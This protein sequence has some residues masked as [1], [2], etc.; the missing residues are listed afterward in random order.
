MS[1]GT[2]PTASDASQRELFGIV[3]QVLK[4][5]FGSN[6]RMVALRRQPSQFRTSFAIDEFEIGLDEGTVL[7]M[8]RKDLSRA[9]LH[10]SALR[11]KPA[12][13]HDPLREIEVYRHVL[14]DV[15]LGTAHCYAAVVDPPRERY[16][17]FLEHVP[18]VELYQVGDLS[19]WRDVARWL[20]AMHCRFVGRTGALARVAPL[21]H[22]DAAFYGRWLDRAGAFVRQAT[23][24]LDAASG[25][26]WERLVR[27]YDRVIARLAAR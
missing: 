2:S 21:L 11:A 3:E 16:W 23:R 24:R 25:A 20:A 18:G 17:L 5:A 7:R 4:G 12:F 9:G 26:R 14:A 8:L 15:G 1:D 27:N 10:E 19:T 13:L 6:R 22:Y